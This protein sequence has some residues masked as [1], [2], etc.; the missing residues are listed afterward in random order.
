MRISDWSSDVCSSELPG[1]PFRDK[2]GARG[3]KVDRLCAPA[4]RDAA[5]RNEVAAARARGGFG[6]DQHAGLQ[7]L[8]RRLAP[9]GGGHAVAERGIFD[10]P[11]APEI[12]AARGS[13]SCMERGC[14][15]GLSP[16]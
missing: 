5:H 13:A 4:Q 10:A 6:G 14:R 1:A 16:W 3:E 9:R 7:A 15:T 2:I 12:A 11:F 8:V